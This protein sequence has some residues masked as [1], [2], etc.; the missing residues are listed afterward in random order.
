MLKKK[1]SESSLR[2]AM[3]RILV[4][5]GVCDVVFTG[6]VGGGSVVSIL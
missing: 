2:D 4:K 1:L 6:I 5:K 3:S